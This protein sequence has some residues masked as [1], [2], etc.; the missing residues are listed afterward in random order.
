MKVASIYDPTQTDRPTIASDHAVLE[1]SEA[2]KVADYLLQSGVLILRTTQRVADLL[3]DDSEPRVP[4]S[5]ATDG[6]WLWNKAV[7]YYVRNHG[8]SPG[9][10]MLDYIRE[11]DYQPRKASQDEIAQISSDWNKSHT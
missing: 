3:G 11:R 1:S 7:E 6:V 4:V 9:Q 5:T 10:E 2:R 8:L